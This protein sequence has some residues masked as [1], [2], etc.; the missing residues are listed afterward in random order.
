VRPEGVRSVRWF[1]LVRKF[2]DG[3][4]DVRVSGGSPDKADWADLPFV[5]TGVDL[6]AVYRLYSARAPY[7]IEV[8]AKRFSIQSQADAVVLSASAQVVVG[9]DGE[10]RVRATYR[11]FNRSRQFLRLKLPEGAVLYGAVAANRP[12]KPLAGLEGTVLLPVP[13]VP[14]GGTG[15]EVSI[16]YRARVGGGFSDGGKATLLLPEVRGVE[17]DRTA[18]TLH[19]PDGFDWSFDTKMTPAQERDVIGER[20]EASLKEASSA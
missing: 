9:L 2:L 16:T 20:L 13:K 7:T 17:V 10:A 12:V 5:P 6:R 14:L 15:Y 1:G 19:V 4:V 3:E 11:L 8:T 18:I